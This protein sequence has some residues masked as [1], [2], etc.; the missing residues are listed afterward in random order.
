MRVITLTDIRLERTLNLPVVG[1]SIANPQLSSATTTGFGYMQPAGKGAFRRLRADTVLPSRSE[2]SRP[3]KVYASPHLTVVVY[4][5]IADRVDAFTDRLMVTTP[6]ELFRAHVRFFHDN[7]D[8]IAP[9][10]LGDGKQPKRP[11]LITFDDAY[12]SVCEVASPILRDRN[13]EAL[14]FINPAAI[15]DRLLPTDNLL[16]LA[17]TVFGEDE[18]AKIAGCNLRPAPSL[19]RLLMT[20]V[21]RLSAPQLAQLRQALLLRLGYTEADLFARTSLIMTPKHLAEL[22]SYGLHAANHTMTHRML[23]V[24]SAA[25]LDYEIRAAKQRIE[26][27]TGQVVRW[28]S[29]PYGCDN[30]A[31][32]DVLEM[33]AA[34]GHAGAFLVQGRLNRYRTAANLLYRVSPRDVRMSLLPVSLSLLPALRSLRHAARPRP[35]AGQNAGFPRLS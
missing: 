21:A 3:P 12:R 5:H 29:V 20:V 17:M 13:M 7:Y 22:G 35:A 30:D 10:D 2:G 14:F 34:S 27:A 19:P 26:Q 11:L 25:E 23:H 4:H 1:R 18:V 28:F 32:A 33:V 6:P 24:L 31:T 15:L 16:C 8:V 9:G